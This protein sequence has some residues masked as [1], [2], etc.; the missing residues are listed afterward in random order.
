MGIAPAQVTGK[1]EP[2]GPTVFAI[3]E[4]DDRRAENV[5]RVDVSHGHARHHFR[6]LLVGNALEPLDHPLDV[7]Q[8]EE[9]LGSLD[10]GVFEMGVAHFFTLDSR[11]VAQ[12]DVGD[13]A[14]RRRRE[15]RSCIAS[16]DQA[17]ETADVVVMGVRHNNRVERAR[18]ERKLAVGA[19][20][21][22]TVGIK[23]PAVEQ[24]PFGIDLQ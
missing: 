19:V 9:R 13:I 5:A 18:V 3:V 15:D 23:Q 8:V 1:N 16:P 14:R 22:N 7:V 17:G 24:D 12:H 20:G 10:L 21:I 6:G 4:L 2:A 11:T